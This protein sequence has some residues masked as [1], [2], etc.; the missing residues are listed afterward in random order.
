MVVL[1]V[2]IFIIRLE[3]E[4]ILVFVLLCAG[5]TEH[6]IQ[7]DMRY[8]IAKSGADDLAQSAQRKISERLKESV[9]RINQDIEGVVNNGQAVVK[10]GNDQAVQQ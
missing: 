5:V 6:F 10:V 1:F 8:R 9:D 4:E 2:L 3:K 7:Y